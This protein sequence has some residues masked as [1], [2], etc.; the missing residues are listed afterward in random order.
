[1]SAHESVLLNESIQALSIKPQGVYIDGT[2]GR[3]GHSKEILKHLDEGGRLIAID[4]DPQAISH[5]K[6]VFAD[7][8]RFSIHQKSFA[9]ILDVAKQEGVVGEVDGILLD[10]GVSSPQLD[11]A[12]RGFS[13]LHDGPLDMRMN[14]NQGIDAASWINTSAVEEM[15][16][17]FKRYGEERFAKRIANAIDKRRC[18][19]QFKTTGEL[20]EVVK[21]ANPKWEKHK[22]PATRVFQAIRIF[23]NNE[24]GDLSQCLNDSIEVLAVKGRLVVISFHSLEDRA[25]KQF[26]KKQA[27]GPQL[28]KEI[29]ISNTQLNI[30]FKTLSKAIKPSQQETLTN[31]RA[32]SAVLRI[33]EK[34]S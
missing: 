22:H 27:Q 15:V 25:V 28:P 23:I 31:P 10:L 14:P 17:V 5:A 4:K 7:E 3:G 30:R 18:E 16:D 8:K 2:F 21:A 34:I 9:Q 32:R 6:K 24:L 11:D 26:M 20:A 33:G 12:E 1:M 29:P 13:F 19:K